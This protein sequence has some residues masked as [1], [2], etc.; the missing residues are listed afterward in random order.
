M[1]DGKGGGSGEAGLRLQQ[2]FGVGEGAADT[3]DDSL[4]HRC[5]ALAAGFIDAFEEEACGMLPRD[6]IS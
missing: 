5:I 4:G 6:G 1:G 3:T 2:Y